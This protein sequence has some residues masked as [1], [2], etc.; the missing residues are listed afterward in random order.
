MNVENVVELIAVGRKPC[1]GN[2]W[3]TT[4]GYSNTSLGKLAVY[5]LGAQ[6]IVLNTTS[7][8]RILATSFVFR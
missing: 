4:A 2:S 7:V 5:P 3:L 8:T 6:L 1:G